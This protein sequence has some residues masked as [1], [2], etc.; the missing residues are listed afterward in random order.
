VVVGIYIYIREVGLDRAVEDRRFGLDGG[1][2]RL[3]DS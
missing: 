1:E 3:M 2:V